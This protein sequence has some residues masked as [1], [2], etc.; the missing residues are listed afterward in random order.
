MPVDVQVRGDRFL[1]IFSYAR[2]LARVKKGGPWIYNRYMLLL[3]DYDG[4]SDPA[5]VPLDFINIWVEVSGLPP[6]LTT[7]PSIVVV[8]ETIGP[9][10]EVEG[11]LILQGIAKVRV[12]LPLH[13]VVRLARRVR[14]SPSAVLALTFKYE[15]LMGR[16][17]SCSR[18]DHCGDRCPQSSAPAVVAPLRPTVPVSDLVFRASS[19]APPPLQVPSL[20]PL[21]KPPAKKVLAVR[22]LPTKKSSGTK[23]AGKK[24]LSN[25]DAP[26]VEFDAETDKN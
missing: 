4:L 5:L 17:R 20:K 12:A 23:T 9:V 24:R 15:R 14:V 2:D 26:E 7:R 11:N 13:G 22:Q 19:S 3:N 10:L 25:G 18:I 8:R 21:V 16:C 1:F 6:E